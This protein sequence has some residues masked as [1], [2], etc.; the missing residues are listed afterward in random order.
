[1]TPSIRSMPVIRVDGPRPDRS[2]LVH[3]PGNLDVPAKSRAAVERLVAQQA[4]G[5]AI[6]YV[7][8]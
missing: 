5:S 2:Y 8:K 4:P 7:A 1:M 3:L 6:R